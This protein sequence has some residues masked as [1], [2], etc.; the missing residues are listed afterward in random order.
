MSSVRLEDRRSA[1]K[2]F[3]FNS[4]V[5]KDLF[6]QMNDTVVRNLDKAMDNESTTHL[7]RAKGNQELI[8]LIENVLKTEVPPKG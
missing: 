4:D 6:K 5:G 3:F 7:S 2:A 8:D 1:Y